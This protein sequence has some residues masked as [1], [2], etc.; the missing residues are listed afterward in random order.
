MFH[1]MLFSEFPI[2]NFL[3]VLPCSHKSQ[4]RG[5]FFV[6]LVSTKL[7]TAFL[8][9]ISNCGVRSNT[10]HE[11]GFKPSTYMVDVIGCELTSSGGAC[12]GSI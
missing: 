2:S 7:Q 1:P 3:Y 4:L 5:E 6:P 12:P 8:S 9:V 10:V 11:A